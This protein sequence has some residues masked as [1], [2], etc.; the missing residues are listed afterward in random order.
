VTRPV[1]AE[2]LVVTTPL[3]LELSGVVLCIGNFD[4]VHLGHQLLLRRLQEAAANLQAPSVV[5]T[6]FP[7]AKVFFQ[8]KPYLTS[9]EEKL[10]LLRR[11]APTAVI[12]TPFDHAYART[13]KEAFLAQLQH[14]APK[15]LIV[16]ED[17]HFGHRRSGGLDD[18]QHVT[19]RLEVFSLRRLEEEPIKSS[20]IRELLRAGQVEQARRFLGYSYLAIGEVIEGDRRGRTVGFPT[21][22]LRLAPEKALP[23]GVFAVQVETPYGTF[24]G[25]ANVGPRP[26]F[27][28][29]PPSLEVHLFDF[30]G[31]LYGKSIRVSFEHFLRAQRRFRGLDELRAQLTEDKERAKA[32]LQALAP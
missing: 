27:P 17:F 22:N 21:A 31:D 13:S 16:G 7:P 9:A 8:G 32:Y 29:A 18:L 24:G 5:L 15:L 25:M 26:S 3:A 10:Y 28:D 30:D 11:F 2:P 6:F 20:H 14:L 23:L 1:D 19:E 4:G 12:M